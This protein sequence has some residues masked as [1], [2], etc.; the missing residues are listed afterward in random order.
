MLLALLAYINIPWVV[1]TASTGNRKGDGALLWN[2]MTPLHLFF[3]NC[4]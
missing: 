2:V 1:Q 3:K 4:N